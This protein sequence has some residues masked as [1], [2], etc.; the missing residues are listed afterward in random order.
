[1]NPDKKYKIHMILK[2]DPK[3]LVFPGILSSPIFSATILSI[4][5]LDS[6]PLFNL[7]RAKQIIKNNID[8]NTKDSLSKASNDL[9]EKIDEA[10]I[11]E[12]GI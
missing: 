4:A 6:I 11:K 12:I 2:T 5:L 3:L 10:E 8:S 9:L 1:M 7:F